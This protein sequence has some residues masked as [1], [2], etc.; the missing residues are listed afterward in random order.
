MAQKTGQYKYRIDS[1]MIRQDYQNSRRVWFLDRVW[2][3][4]RGNKQTENICNGTRDYCL[5]EKQILTK[6]V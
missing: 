3:D 1:C 2:T 6:G 5:K 4:E